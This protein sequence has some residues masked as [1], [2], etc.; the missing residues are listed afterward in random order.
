MSQLKLMT[1]PYHPL[2]C[3]QTDNHFYKEK[4]FVQS[5]LSVLQAPNNWG[6]VDSY[7]YTTRIYVYYWKSM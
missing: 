3:Y 5:I 6:Y 1:R 7:M 4:V 2:N